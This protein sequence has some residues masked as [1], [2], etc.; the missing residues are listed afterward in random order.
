MKQKQPSASVVIYMEG[1]RRGS[2]SASERRKVNDLRRNMRHLFDSLPR[3][4]RV[5]ACG[6]RNEAVNLFQYTLSRGEI[7][8]LLI[9]SEAE[10]GA[11]EETIS[12][13]QRMAATNND[14]QISLPAGATNQ[15]VYLI[16]QCMETWFLAD[17]EALA[18]YY[19]QGFNRN[20][21]PKSKELEQVA[22]LDVLAALKA[23]TRQTQR[24]EYQKRHGLE[25]LGLLD[26]KKLAGRCPHFASLLLRIGELVAAL[27][28]QIAAWHGI[29]SSTRTVLRHFAC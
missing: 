18:G 20:A 27:G 21:L 15:N 26:R 7:A 2:D 19:K 17:V 10:K 11:T 16:V 1:G 23:A 22:K 13:F 8:I 14:A 5:V 29:I 28:C 24:G 3:H 25:L 4:P 6:S 9:D 12:F